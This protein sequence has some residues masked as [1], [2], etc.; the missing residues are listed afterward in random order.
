MISLEYLTSSQHY[1]LRPLLYQFYHTFV[2]D[3][4]SLLTCTH[5][6]FHVIHTNE[7]K[8][9]KLRP[10]R[11]AWK[12]QQIV[13]QAVKDMLDAG[14]IR[15]SRSPWTFLVILMPKPD[16]STRFCIDYW[17]LNEISKKS[18]YLSPRTKDALAAL[19]RA[20]FFPATDLRSG[21][22]QIPMDSASIEK[23]AFTTKFGLFEFVRIHFCFSSAVATF[24]RIMNDVF[25][26]LLW[27]YVVVYIDDIII[28]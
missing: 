6:G 16:G 8:P 7:A 9:I 10:H 4:K 27:E 18:A 19:S 24:Q 22:W 2:C 5:R 28:Y 26:D 17:K 13:R 12:E 11:M 1:N 20:K 25:R 14:V 23:T 15:P 21:Y 3:K